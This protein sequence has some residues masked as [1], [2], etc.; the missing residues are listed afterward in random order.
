MTAAT[1]LPLYSPDV[2]ALAVELASY[3]LTPDLPLHGEAASRTCGSRTAVG[4]ALDGDAGIAQV[5]IR[6]TACAIGQAAA[7]LFAKAAAG[8]TRIDIANAESAITAWLSGH[9]DLPGWPQFEL[10]DAA[11]SFPARH[12]AILL[13]WK[14]AAAAL[15]IAPTRA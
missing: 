10:L 12:A 5:G 6:A 2:L 4:L 8:A 9:G 15:S 3:P 11:R 13:P 7:A 14:A 1:T